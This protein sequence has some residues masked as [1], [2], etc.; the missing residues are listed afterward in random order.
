MRTS[1][2][3]ALLFALALT[4][5]FAKGKPASAG[6]SD[7]APST[8][9]G[10]S[11]AHNTT[12]GKSADHAKGHNDSDQPAGWDQG[13]KTGWHDCDVPPGQARKTSADC[14]DKKGLRIFKRKQKDAKKPDVARKPAPSGGTNR[15]IT[16]TTTTTTTSTT[17]PASTSKTTT[18]TTTT[19]GTKRTPRTASTDAVAKIEAKQNK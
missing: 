12:H 9:K 1:S 7:K 5:A 3:I 6:K 14:D 8:A 19:T 10:Q 18:T 2:L 15:P 16:R 13:K 4:P 11:Q 17:K